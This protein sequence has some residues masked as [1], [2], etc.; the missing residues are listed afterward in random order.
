PPTLGKDRFVMLH[1]ITVKNHSK[2]SEGDVSQMVRAIRIQISNDFCPA[3]GLR[4][5]DIL[6]SPPKSMPSK[7]NKFGV[8]LLVDDEYADPD[9]LGHHTE[10]KDG[11]VYAVVNVGA[12]MKADGVPL[13]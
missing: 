6:Y 7:G 1:T 5:V 12:V 2:L 11:T 10:E 4:T 13:I 8:L 3:Y 9:E